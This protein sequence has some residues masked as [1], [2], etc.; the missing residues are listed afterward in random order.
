LKS[1]GDVGAGNTL[2]RYDLLTPIAQ[3][4]MA[5]VWA[6][7]LRGSRGFQKIVAVKAMLPSLSE[8]AAFEEMFLAEA[9]LAS[10]IKHPNV[11]EIFDVGE[12]DGTPY[13]VMEW[14]NGEPLSTL[15]KASKTKGPIPLG[16]G[17]RIAHGAALGLHAAHEVK[18][19]DG[20]LVGLVHRDVSPQNILVGFDGIVKVVD[21]GIAK[22]TAANDDK[23]TQ[24]GQIKG[25]INYMSP[26]QT[27]GNADRRSDI[28]ALGIV[29][30]MLLTGKHPFAAESEMATLR[31]ICSNES[32]EPPSKIVAE[33][34]PALDQAVMRALEKTPSRR[35]QT[36]A[37]FAGALEAARLAI[38]ARAE[39][40]DVGAFVTE[41]LGERVARRQRAIKDALRI[42]DERV[43][44]RALASAL[45]ANSGVS[46]VSGISGLH[47]PVSTTGP[48]QFADSEPHSVTGPTGPHLR[49]TSEP[50]LPAGGLF[51]P[52]ST[53]RT[54]HSRSDAGVVADGH[55]QSAPGNRKALYVIAIAGVLA[56]AGVGVLATRNSKP[57]PSHA[58]ASKPSATTVVT[59]TG[60]PTVAAP[61]IELSALP[62]APQASAVANA[63]SDS[64]GKKVTPVVR[65]PVGAHPAGPVAVR[66]AAPA[67]GSDVK[68]RD[69]G[70]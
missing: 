12:E 33:I 17:V 3:G 70:F 39:S 45:S 42:A 24:A 10:R 67:T 30:Y 57:P 35:F 31:R 15:I 49:G 61:A 47:T 64:S 23:K 46:S 6:A 16:V 18:G 28:F 54:P 62:D 52:S 38:A 8:D 48:F 60:A 55:P 43:N 7:R 68:V 20:V 32:V 26:E 22:A 4:G 44:D 37:E 65:P 5:I 25:K 1:L 58:A 69:P 59:S 2:G 27:L 63:S 9:E 14:V 21:F 51:A 29:V 19:E 34:P 50:H 66:T 40:P 13:I 41:R 11:C 36:M 56:A 53:G